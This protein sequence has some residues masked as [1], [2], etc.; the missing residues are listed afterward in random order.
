MDDRTDKERIK[1]L[2]VRID[3]LV[4]A[5][6]AQNTLM[7]IFNQEFDV[8]YARINRMQRDANMN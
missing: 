6:Q 2:E 5:A 4:K 1:D 8:L 3:L 7:N